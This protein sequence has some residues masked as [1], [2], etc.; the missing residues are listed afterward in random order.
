MSRIDKPIIIGRIGRIW[1][2][3]AVLFMSGFFIMLFSGVD[4]GYWMTETNDKSISMSFDT[5]NPIINEREFGILFIRFKNVEDLHITPDNLTFV[6]FTA[7][8]DIFDLSEGEDETTCFVRLENI[9]DIPTAKEKSIRID[10]GV[11]TI[12]GKN[13]AAIN[14]K[15]NLKFISENRSLFYSTIIFFVCNA[16]FLLCAIFLSGG[17]VIAG[18]FLSLDCFV[19]DNLSLLAFARVLRHS[20]NFRHT[21]YVIVLICA[22]VFFH[23]WMAKKAL[24]P[25]GYIIAIVC[26]ATL[27]LINLSQ[28][29]TMYYESIHN[30]Y[31]LS[32]IYLPNIDYQLDQVNI[33]DNPWIYRIGWSLYNVKFSF[34]YFFEF[35]PEEYYGWIAILQFTIG[36]IYDIVLLGS[37][38]TFILEHYQRNKPKRKT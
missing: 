27:S 37:I 36:K 31:S 10:Q 4:D 11:V 34:R 8:I 9:T 19:F 26:L 7:E 25:N 1:L 18:F 23:L 22:D 15:M 5:R 21:I 14:L 24:K 28:V 12:S 16:F 20:S 35:P 38:G 2:N 3:L 29:F 17:T 33:I 13:N 6:G 32:L 30:E